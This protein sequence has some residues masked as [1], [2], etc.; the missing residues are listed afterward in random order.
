M[1]R[2]DDLE[3][4]PQ[5]QDEPQGRIRGLTGRGREEAEGLE[6]GGRAAKPDGGEGG[7][8]AVGRCA[9]F[10]EDGERRD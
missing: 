6:G 2:K 7:A 8:G 5:A 10:R 4:Q 1:S 9:R 3:V